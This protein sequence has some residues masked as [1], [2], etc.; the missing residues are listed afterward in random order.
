MAF[1]QNRKENFVKR[2]FKKGKIDFYSLSFS[3][4]KINFT[5]LAQKKKEKL[6]IN[7]LIV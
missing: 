3:S 6:A 4:N 1:Y 2:L 7:L 5:S